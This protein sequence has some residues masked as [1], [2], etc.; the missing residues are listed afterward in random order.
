MNRTSTSNGDIVA[1]EDLQGLLKR[2]DLSFPTRHT[3]LVADAGVHA[4]GLELVIV[5]HRSHEL[6]LRGCEVLLRLSKGGLGALFLFGLVLDV[7]PLRGL[8]HLRVEDEL[9]ENL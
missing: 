3:V 7:R 1:S 5:V 6:F 4:R 9:V 8:L 2:L